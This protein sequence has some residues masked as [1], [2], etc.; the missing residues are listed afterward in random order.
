VKRGGTNRC[1]HRGRSGRNRIKEGGRRRRRGRRR[2]TRGR[3]ERRIRG[4]VRIV[5]V[6]KVSKGATR[7]CFFFLFFWVGR[8]VDSI[9]EPIS[10]SETIVLNQSFLR[11][12]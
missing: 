4:M 8:E 12:F 7:M 1:I 6:I 11:Q 5:F 9:S 2:R 10:I 3:K